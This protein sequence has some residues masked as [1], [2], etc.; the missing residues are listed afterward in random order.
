MN[1]TFS[2]PSGKNWKDGGVGTG[3]NTGKEMYQLFNNTQ[4]TNQATAAFTRGFVRPPASQYEIRKSLAQLL[5]EH[6][7]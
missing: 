2:N 4:N 6:M 1:E 3:V 7:K 5:R